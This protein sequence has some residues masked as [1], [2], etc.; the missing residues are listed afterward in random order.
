MATGID[1][2]TR[3]NRRRRGTAL[4]EQVFTL[5]PTFALIFAFFDYGLMLF[6]WST[7]QNAVREGARYAITYRRE[8]GLNHDASIKKRVK[9][10]AMN[11]V[12]DDSKIF[13]DYFRYDSTINDYVRITGPAAATA[14]Q[15]GNVVEVSVRGMSYAWLAPLSGNFF[16]ASAYRQRTPLTLN[17]YSSDV[18]NGYPAGVTSVPR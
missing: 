5:M 13:I 17:I 7:L 1:L 3:R 12:T 4:L 2:N 16:S 9:Q 14:N 6:R 8:A 10:Y 11:M 15:P 18:M